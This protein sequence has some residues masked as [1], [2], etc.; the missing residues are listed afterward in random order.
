M[1]KVYVKHFIESLN[2]LCKKFKN[3]CNKNK[4]IWLMSNE[5]DNV[6][7]IFANNIYIVVFN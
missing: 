1:N 6:I 4:F 3:L 5:G 2:S 7:E